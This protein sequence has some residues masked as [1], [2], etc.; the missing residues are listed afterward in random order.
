[1]IKIIGVFVIIILTILMVLD[2][3]LIL[4]ILFDLESYFPKEIIDSLKKQYATNKGFNFVNTV[5]SLGILIGLL[6]LSFRNIA[7][8][9]QTKIQDKIFNQDKQF[10]NFLE[11]TKLLTDKDSTAEAKIAAMFSLADVAKEYPE[12]LDRVVQV[13]NKELVPLIKVIDVKKPLERQKE[14]ELFSYTQNKI[15]SYNEKEKINQE[16]IKNWQHK[17]TETEKVVSV[18]LLKFH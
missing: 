1:M 3:I 2:V 11:A 7:M 16:N 10:S 15:V 5:S 8:N 9:N 13:L 14:T 18:A 12:H 4:G 6:I 17:G